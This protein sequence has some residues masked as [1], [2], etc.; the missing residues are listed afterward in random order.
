MTSLSIKQI[1]ATGLGALSLLW[2]GAADAA[3]PLS[4]AGTWA[5]TGNQTLGS[6]VITQTANT[7]VCK[8]IIGSI[9]GSAIEGFYCP[10]TGRIVFARRTATGVPFQLYEGYVARDAAIDRIGGT[11]KIWN[12][13]GGGLSNEGVDFNFSATK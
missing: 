10:V 13:T 2:I 1:L 8:P 6:L 5:A 4:V 12:A 11:F 7:A 3:S 9:F